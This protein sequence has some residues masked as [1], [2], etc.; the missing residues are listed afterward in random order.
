MLTST[1]LFTHMLSRKENNANIKCM[2]NAEI[3]N[4]FEINCGFCTL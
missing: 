3:T 1:N 2:A 4:S